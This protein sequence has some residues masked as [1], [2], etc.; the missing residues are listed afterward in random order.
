[1]QGETLVPCLTHSEIYNHREDGAEARKDGDLFFGRMNHLLS[2]EWR[3][4]L[5]LPIHLTAIEYVVAAVCLEIM[6]KG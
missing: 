4:P 1:V 6:M 2:A 5:H 3:H